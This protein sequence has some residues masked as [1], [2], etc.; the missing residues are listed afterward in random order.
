MIA[1]IVNYTFYLIFD[2]KH[3][4]ERIR[5]SDV[6]SSSSSDQEDHNAELKDAGNDNN[7]SR[8]DTNDFIIVVV[9]GKIKTKN[10]ISKANKFIFP[11]K[12]ERYTIDYEDIVTIINNGP[13]INNREQYVFHLEP[14]LLEGL[15]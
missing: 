14:K 10:F 8:P 11:E 12:E 6:Y 3:P 13:N 4:R 2:D 9:K 1:I 5:Y 15:K 7:I